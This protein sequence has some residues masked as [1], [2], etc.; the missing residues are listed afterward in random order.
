MAGHT[1]TP[2]PTVTTPRTP[3]EAYQELIR[4]LRAAAV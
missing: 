3:D 1:N 4:R 2:A